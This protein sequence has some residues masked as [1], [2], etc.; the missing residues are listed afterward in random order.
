MVFSGIY[1]FIDYEHGGSAE[2]YITALDRLIGLVN[3]STKIIPGHGPLCY[4]KYLV[5]FRGMLSAITS[6]VRLM[7]DSGSSLDDV[8]GA[9]PSAKFDERFGGFIKPD[10]FVT[11]VYKSLK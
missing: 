11:L 8:I 10:D 1:P 2:G 6:Q 5:E 3:D 9:K 7:K 4:K